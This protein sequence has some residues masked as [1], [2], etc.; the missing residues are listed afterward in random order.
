[1]ALFSSGVPPFNVSLAAEVN[2]GQDIQHYTI[3]AKDF[4][5]KN[6]ANDTLKGGTPE[7]NK[8]IAVNNRIMLNIL[9]SIDFI[10]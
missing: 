6:A 9:A 3:N 2:A 4:G 1:M 5:L 8:A 10:Y 7:E